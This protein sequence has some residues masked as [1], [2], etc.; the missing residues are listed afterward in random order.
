MLLAIVVFIAVTGVIVG[1]YVAVT[2]LP[3]M[4]K[5]RH[6]ERR[7]RDVSAPAAAP[8]KGGD[9]VVVKSDSDALLDRMA[10][11]TRGGAWLSHLIE[12]S[13][14]RTS[15]S[16]IILASIGAAAL[17]GIAAVVLVRQNLALPIAA[18][19]GMSL[20]TVFLMRKRTVRLHRFEEMFPEA[21][22]LLSRAVKAGHAFQTAMNMAADELPDPVGPE[23]RKTFDQ[24][25][26]GLPMRDALNAMSERIPIIDVKFFVTAVLI[27]RETGGNLSEI[28]DNLSHVVRERFKVL[29]QV[30]VHTAHGR[31][32]G[33]VLLALPATLAMVMSWINPEHM[34][35]LFREPMGR[36]ML[37]TAAVMQTIGYFWI[38]RVIKIEV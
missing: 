3:G 33:W 37:I 22:D 10:A 32:T 27:Q 23:F 29:R 20:P 13:G 15:P 26:F 18:G 17:L 6:L 14:V 35:L 31:F 1:G 12:Q 5:K 25:N 34:Q 7:L 4:M 21:L 30:R 16:T 24:Q 9:S 11:G 38:K 28:L 8:V 2:S 19:V 36:A